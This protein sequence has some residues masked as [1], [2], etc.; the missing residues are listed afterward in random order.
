VRELKFRAWDKRKREM[1]YNGVEFEMRNIEYACKC[2]PRCK[3][4]NEFIGY[5]KGCPLFAMMQFTGLRDRNGKE[6]YEDDILQAD[7]P[8]DRLTFS[9]KWYDY[10]GTNLL[11]INTEAFLVIGNRF[12]NPDLLGDS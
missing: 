2:E 7:D 1:V 3:E 5:A 12:E 9:V 11:G 8:K 10:G 4:N 6:I